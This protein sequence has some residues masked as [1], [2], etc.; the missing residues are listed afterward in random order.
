LEAH[1]VF[2]R[3]ASP[4]VWTTAD[5]K[6][7]A[8]PIDAPLAI[9]AWLSGITGDAATQT[10]DTLTAIGTSAILLAATVFEIDALTQLSPQTISHT[11]SRT[12][13]QTMFG[14][15]LGIGFCA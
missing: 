14:F 5:I 4:V 10:I 2:S 12:A 9:G 7:V 13:W 15:G 8:H 11:R 1:L 3:R 6:A